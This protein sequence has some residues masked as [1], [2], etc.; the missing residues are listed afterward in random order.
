MPWSEEPACFE[1]MR[2]VDVRFGTVACSFTVALQGGTLNGVN[3]GL[4]T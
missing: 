3:V 1:N 2:G 4:A